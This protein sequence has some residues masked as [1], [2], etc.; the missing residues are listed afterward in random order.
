MANWFVLNG[1][2]AR[3][4]S[5]LQMA[6]LLRAAGLKI[7]VGSYSL[8]IEDFDCFRFQHYG[9]D[10]GEPQIEADAETLDDLVR[11]AARVSEALARSG[12]RHRFEIYEDGQQEL[13][14][15]LHHDWP[16]TDVII[17]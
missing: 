2:L 7:Y 10:L 13:R 4:P 9:G 6:A 14:G 8:R 1:Q 16:L 11:Q 12:I 15:Y 5:K 17:P 3:W